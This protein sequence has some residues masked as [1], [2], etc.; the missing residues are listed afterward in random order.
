MIITLTITGQSVFAHS[1]IDNI[2][3]YYPFK[4]LHLAVLFGE[5]CEHLK[6]IKNDIFEK[7]FINRWDLFN[8]YSLPNKIIDSL[9]NRI[10]ENCLQDIKK[11]KNI[12]NKLKSEAYSE[13]YFRINE[14]FYETS[15]LITKISIVLSFIKTDDPRY[16]GFTNSYQS[17]VFFCRN[18]FEEDRYKIKAFDAMT[19]ILQS[20][21]N[22]LDKTKNNYFTIS[23]SKLKILENEYD[24]I[25]EAIK[26]ECSDTYQETNKDNS[27]PG[28]PWDSG[29]INNPSSAGSPW[30]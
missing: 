23:K 4:S 16:Y 12:I 27:V 18:H 1:D 11:N 29:G 19:E 30:D 28:V 7:D 14:V 20:I 22:T 6:I 9:P 8:I 25:C 3:V 2:K 15:L 17:N 5:S 21:E 26:K 10:I 24:E 13:N